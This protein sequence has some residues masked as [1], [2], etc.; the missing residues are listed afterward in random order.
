MTMPEDSTREFQPIP[1]KRY[2]TISEASKLCGV[3]QS[4]LRY[5]EDRFNKL[6]KVQ[7]RNN[8]RYFTRDDL[9]TVRQISVLL[10]DRNYTADAVIDHFANK[11]EESSVRETLSFTLEIQEVIKE[12]HAIKAELQDK[13]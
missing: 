10:D 9:M 2:F 11:P 6:L 5:W 8:R 7:R 1:D 12:L 4:K 3:P 13:S